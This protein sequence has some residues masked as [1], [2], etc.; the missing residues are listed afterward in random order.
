M[1][2]NVSRQWREF[3]TSNAGIAGV[4]QDC[5]NSIANC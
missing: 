4:G 1:D 5:G 3:F 2:D